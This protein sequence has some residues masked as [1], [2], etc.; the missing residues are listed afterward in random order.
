MNLELMKS[1]Y[2]RAT[3]ACT[4][5][6]AWEFETAF[7]EEVMKHCVDICMQAHYDVLDTSIPLGTSDFDRGIRTGQKTMAIALAAKLK[8]VLE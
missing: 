2:T 8:K 7:A 4:N 1:L 6:D 3:L 5:G